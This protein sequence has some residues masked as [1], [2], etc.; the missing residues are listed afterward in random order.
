MRR[1]ITLALLA[2]AL[3]GCNAEHWIRLAF[4]EH[5]PAVQAEAVDVA[6]CESSLNPSATNGEY[7]GLFQL[8]H[9]HY[10]RI[11]VYGGDW[12]N[13]WQNAEAASDLYAEQGWRPWSC[14]P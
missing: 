13:P 11:D 12:A 1:L 8:G 3:T 7:L 9:Y 10:W 2:V 14:R 4:E 6:R 5:G